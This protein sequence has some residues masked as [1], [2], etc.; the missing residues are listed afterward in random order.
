LKKAKKRG[1]KRGEKRGIEA[2]EVK[3]EEEILRHSVPVLLQKGFSAEEI[4]EILFVP[5]AKVQ[6]IITEL[7]LL[8]GTAGVDPHTPQ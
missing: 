2:G 4:A 7:S 3:R 8:P 6:A 1:E 5:L